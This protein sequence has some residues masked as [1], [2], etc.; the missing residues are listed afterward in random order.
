MISLPPFADSVQRVSRSTCLLLQKREHQIIEQDSEN[1]PSVLAVGLQLKRD[2][3]ILPPWGRMTISQTYE[4][5]PQN[6][7]CSALRWH[8]VVDTSVS[9]AG[10]TDIIR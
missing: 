1:D 2:L 10:Q 4:M 7:S 6:S 9:I 8:Q 3:V 5:L